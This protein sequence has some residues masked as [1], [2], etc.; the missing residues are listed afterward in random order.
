[1]TSPVFERVRVI[2]ADVLKLPA[3][4]ITAQTSPEN[5]EGWDSV[6]HLN[7][8]LALE[9]DFSVQFEPEEIDQMSSV[10]RIL[11]VLQSKLNQN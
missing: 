7:L 9:Q 11:T 3:S 10:E 2:T 8:I 5:V 1:M 4:Q 6:Q